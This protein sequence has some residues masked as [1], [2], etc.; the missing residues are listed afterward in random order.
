MAP[1]K[2]LPPCIGKGLLK[3]LSREFLVVA[4]PE[5]FTSK[6]CFKC[7]G[8]CGNHAYLAERD[9]RV[10]SDERL[11]QRLAERL[12]RCETE[13]QRDTARVRRTTAACLA[14][15]RSEGCVSAK[16]AAAA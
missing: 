10:Q 12:E 15:V 11:E 13:A 5:H 9:R 7:G 6:K 3:K 16:A 2:G 1:C 8:S 4:V 14:R